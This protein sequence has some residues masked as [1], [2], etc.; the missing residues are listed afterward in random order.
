MLIDDFDYY[1]PENLIA[2]KPSLK[3]DDCRLLFLNKRNGE[4][5]HDKFKSIE[6]ELN[7]NDV[8]VLN[9]SK[10][11]PARLHGQKKLTEGKIELLLHHS[12]SI[13]NKEIW[14]VMI[15]GKI[16]IETILE[17]KDGLEAKVLEKNE[18]GLCKIEFNKKNREFFKTINKIGETPLPPYI[19]REKGL[20]KNDKSDY[21][22][23][24]ASDDKVG[25]SAAPTAGLHF[26]KEML[27]RLEEKGVQIIY[28]TLHVGLGTF[29][30]VK[31]KNMLDH[32]MH[33]EFVSIKTNYVK[34]LVEAREEKRRI[35][36]VGTT[37]CRA[38]ESLVKLK[39]DELNTIDKVDNKVKEEISF[40]TDIYIYP[41]YKFELTNALITN[42]HLPKSTL[43]LLVG[44]LAKVENIKKAYKEAIDLK[45][46]F[47]SYG[48]A[49]FIY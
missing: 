17:F 16:N 1:L 10:V 42:F 25:S 27:N 38:I 35:I 5:R 22:T 31:T 21:Q 2:Q 23:V 45:Y 14:E 32:K 29:A 44:A 36:A 11:F 6:N 41:G 34:K 12:L 24:F 4:I 40:W 9:N 47:F 26:S 43:L 13:Q 19:K 15:K 20:H 37:S 28:V 49:M 46:R 8:L 7:R 18:D 48:D 3:R 33:S 30:P 39:S